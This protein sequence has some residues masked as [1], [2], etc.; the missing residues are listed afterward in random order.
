MHIIL[1][2]NQYNIKYFIFLHFNTDIQI[3]IPEETITTQ[4]PDTIETSSDSPT[5][6]PP[7]STG[8]SDNTDA[9]STAGKYES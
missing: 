3:H 4:T 9:N 1:L 5:S 2:S 7:G 8:P 6:L